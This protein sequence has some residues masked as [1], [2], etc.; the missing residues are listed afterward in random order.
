MTQTELLDAFGHSVWFFCSEL[1]LSKLFLSRRAGA[2]GGKEGMGRQLKRVRDG[3]RHQTRQVLDLVS[4]FFR[5]EEGKGK[6]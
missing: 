4:S 6:S 3:K 2:D 1:G 5:W